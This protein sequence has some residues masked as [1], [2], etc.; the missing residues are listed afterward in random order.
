MLAAA[1]ERLKHVLALAGGDSAAIVNYLD[2]NL[3]GA[4]ACARDHVAA[5]WR[6]ADRVVKEIQQHAPD[7]LGVRARD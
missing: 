4:P 6:V 7:L 5:R 3:V 1:K 2:F